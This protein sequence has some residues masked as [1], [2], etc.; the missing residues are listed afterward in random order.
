M[1][2]RA[3]QAIP[4]ILW[5][6]IAWFIIVGM[7]YPFKNR[8]KLVKIY[9]G[10]AI[11]VR[12]ENVH[13][14]IEPFAKLLSKVPEWV[15]EV[16]II[17]VFL[18]SMVYLVPAP[19]QIVGVPGFSFPSFFRILGNNVYALLTVKTSSPTSLVT[20]KFV[21]LAP[22]IPGV[23]IDLYTFMY[24][25]IAIGIGILVHEFSHGAL[26][27]RFKS[28][29]KSGGAF[30]S[31]F[32]LYGGFVELDEKEMKE[33]LSLPQLLT[34][35]GGGVFANLLLAYL[36]VGLLLIANL[37]GLINYIGGV[38]IAGVIK[39]YPAYQ[40]GIVNGSVLLYANG[41]AVQ[42]TYSLLYL[43]EGAKPGEHLILTTLS[44]GV[45]SNHLI[46]LAS[47]PNAPGFPFIGVM[48]Q[49]R[50]FYNFLYWFWTLNVTLV[51]LNSMP[52][53]P[54]DGGQ[55]IYSLLA[56]FAGERRAMLVTEVLSIVVWGLII[57]TI[58]IS[59][60]TGLWQLVAP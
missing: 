37:P 25:L 23:T 39:G 54:L 53:F 45:I 43:L 47:D 13:Q 1:G 33:K 20:H 40:A 3:V 16:L 5:L 55:F 51:L 12:G 6:F 36:A 35:Y 24:V 22:L 14:A 4:S 44:N 9:Y 58:Y 30:L 2:V 10:L 56:R 17:G 27:I 38:V 42:S 21:P 60:S 46:T 11:L 8:L 31:L 57:L 48:V 52:A 28:R 29:V 19:L 18:S 26:A 50:E 7:L 15:L 59:I 32:L 34:V 41:T 49:N